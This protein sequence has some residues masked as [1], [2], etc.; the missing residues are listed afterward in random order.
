M[1]V[2]GENEAWVARDGDKPEPVTVVMAHEK[3]KL[4]GLDLELT[5]CLD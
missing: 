4:K 2:N 5:V 3:F 1:A